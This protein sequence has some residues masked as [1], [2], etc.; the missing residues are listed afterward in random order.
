MYLVFSDFQPPEIKTCLS[1]FSRDAEGMGRVD[2]GPVFPVGLASRGLT[3]TVMGVSV[4]MRGQGRRKAQVCR[5]E[6]DRP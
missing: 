5:A 4:G 6:E 1:C 3:A 2:H